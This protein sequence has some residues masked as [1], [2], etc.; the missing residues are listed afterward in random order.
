MRLRRDLV[1]N[2]AATVGGAGQ[3]PRSAS[4][5]CDPYDARSPARV[6]AE[7]VVRTQASAVLSQDSPGKCPVNPRHAGQVEKT[8]L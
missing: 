4:S 8:P 6:A 3:H 2:T 5:R 7:P 1:P